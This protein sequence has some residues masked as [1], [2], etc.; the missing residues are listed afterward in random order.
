MRPLR[1]DDRANAPV[2]IIIALAAAAI[3]AVILFA[4]FSGSI[5]SVA[6]PCKAQGTVRGDGQ[7][8]AGASLEIFT[9]TM[10]DG[11]LVKQTLAETRTTNDGGYTIGASCSPGPRTLR[12]SAAGFFPSDTQLSWNDGQAHT[13]T[14][15][16][17]LQV[18]LG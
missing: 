13:D 15:N 3:A 12:A 14:R 4:A 5:F 8:L 9:L 10:V 18:N 17:D 16:F 11:N 7:L 6:S 1:R 2:G